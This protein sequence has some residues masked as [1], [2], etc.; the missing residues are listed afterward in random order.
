M[1]M[2][3][4]KQKLT[5]VRLA[6]AL[7]SGASILSSMAATQAQ[8]AKALVAA[9][10]ES[11]ALATAAV[12]P[13]VDSWQRNTGGGMVQVSM[14]TATQLAR[15]A[16]FPAAAGPK[17]L[18]VAFKD[19]MSLD[20]V[21]RMLIRDLERDGGRAA[22]MPHAVMLL[23]LGHSL[24]ARPMGVASSSMSLEFAPGLGTRV[25]VD[26]NAVT[27]FLGDAAFFAYLVKPWLSAADTSR[28]AGSG[29]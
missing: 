17:R 3:M 8:P 11:P 15:R 26:N 10:A 1:H 9:A 27:D 5:I 21:G 14:Y 23:Q 29:Q 2:P 22:V 28:R 25:L 19:R 7:A 24:G 6:M 4:K 12:A 13:P 20:Q 18:H 16:D